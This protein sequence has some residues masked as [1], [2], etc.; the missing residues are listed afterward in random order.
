MGTLNIAAFGGLEYGVPK[1]ELSEYGAQVSK[2]MQV[3]SN[4]FTP[5]RE[6]EA[7]FN[8]VPLTAGTVARSMFRYPYR[9]IVGAQ[10]LGSEKIVDVVKSQAVND[11]YE[12]C[13][14][15]DDGTIGTQSA[16]V[17]LYG[18]L[19]SSTCLL[20][21]PAPTT[22]M[23]KA[24]VDVPQLTA[25]YLATVQAQNES[26]V[27]QNLAIMLQ[28]SWAGTAASAST[29]GYLDNVAASDAAATG[30]GMRG[31]KPQ[32]S[33]I[34]GVD[35]NGITFSALADENFA[36]AMGVPYTVHQ[37]TASHAST[38]PGAWGALATGVVASGNFAA[39][40]YRSFYPVYTF[41]SG[42]PEN[43]A[44]A[45]I[46]ALVQ[47]G[48]TPSA[49]LITAPQ[50]AAL[51]TKVSALFSA[52]SPDVAPYISRINFRYLFLTQLMD[53]KIGSAALSQLNTY[54]ANSADVQARIDNAYTAFAGAVWDKMN[55]ARLT[56]ANATTTYTGTTYS[57]SAIFN[58]VRNSAL[59]PII[60]AVKARLTGDGTAPVS[61]GIAIRSISKANEYLNIDKLGLY[62][63]ATSSSAYDA[64]FQASLALDFTPEL[65]ALYNA[66]TLEAMAGLPDF[67]ATFALGGAAAAGEVIGA[68]DLLDL[69]I[70]DLEAYYS[71]LKDRIKLSIRE[72]FKEE[73]L[74]A[75][76]GDIDPTGDQVLES[77][78]YTHTYVN[79]W[80]EE[81]QDWASI[82]TVPLTEIEV[83]QNDTVNLTRV[84]SVPTGYATI[85]K[86]R[87]YRSN[88]GSG[89][90]RFQLV[91][92]LPIAT[93]TFSDTLLNS[94]L[95]EALSTSTWSMPP[96]ETVN[97]VLTYLQGLV[98]M[99]GNFAAGFID[100]TVY[101]CEIGAY[102]A[103][104][105]EY[106]I[107]MAHRIVGMDVFGN[108]LVVLTE[109]GPYYITGSDP[110]AMSKSDPES[111]QPCLSKKSI[112]KVSGGVVFASPNGL[113][114]A[115]GAGVQL[116][117]P[118][119]LGKAYWSIFRPDLMQCAEF[120]G[121][122]YIAAGPY[123]DAS[124]GINPDTGA[125]Y[126]NGNW[127]RTIGI[128]LATMRIT[129]L[130]LL[131][132]AWYA[133]KTTDTLYAA[134]PHNGA[135]P[136]TKKVLAG[137]ANRLGQWRSKRIT[138][139]REDGYAWL[140]VMGEQSTAS[141]FGATVKLY[142]YVT[143]AA[144][145]EIETTLVNTTLTNTNPVRVASGYF[146]E[147]EV[148]ISS[149]AQ[150]KNVIFAGTTDELQGA[151]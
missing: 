36:W 10:I 37:F 132:T 28:R 31:D 53:G 5:L 48:V 59:A 143:N 33:R 11:V 18:G 81:S 67:P 136:Q 40:T 7:P 17:V 27:L 129:S 50:L 76:H 42:S 21:V 88:G 65:Q 77:R 41:G 25:S 145:T 93:T 127:Q 83:D 110:A 61:P 35:G 131:V 43:A 22:E 82:Q 64:V 70:G 119:K 150:I 120:D 16:P 30:Y 19:T 15:V 46:Q 78:Y 47:P 146:L 87:I 123:G 62:Q 130:D 124:L 75:L 3:L 114:L 14:L 39:F 71:G 96:T 101:F 122:L 151:T 95:Q 140:Q 55:K 56:P 63:S 84:G 45:A 90:D 108:T 105:I 80:G 133:D 72:F 58:T 13:Y 1:R 126:P 29:P 117:L 148:E 85:T 102:Y 97:G 49:F 44:R 113:C 98:N 26:L 106:A 112:A 2:N 52:T 104:P 141:G 23:T 74:N 125:T 116:F 73:G 149:K 66:T 100:R 12:R 69:A 6:D 144:G 121:V 60:Y 32:Q 20:G 68:R 92:E 109:G 91:K 4:S 111:N 138:L 79:E 137:S 103:W 115:S 38:L 86:W 89:T 99:P 142:G 147:F 128:N 57:A 9:N 54:L 135:I 118:A 51:E 139:P 8:L 107:P 34:F 134:L 24:L 94:D